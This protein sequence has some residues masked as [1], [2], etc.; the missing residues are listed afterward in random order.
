MNIMKNNKIKLTTTAVCFQALAAALNLVGGFIALSLRL[1]IYLDSIGTMLAAALLG[2]LCGMIPGLVSGLVSGFTSDIYALYYIPVQLITGILT[3]IV[4][5]KM[6][7][8]KWRLIP[9]AA[10]ISLPGTV[11]SSSI[12]AIVFGGITSSGS[13]ILVQL[14]SHTG[15]GLTASV[16]VVQ[17]LTDYADRVLSLMLTVAVLAA[18]PSSVKNS[19]WKGQTTN[20][21]V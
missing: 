14:L 17:A 8:R 3:G 15:L 2:P 20:G 16:C 1:P 7:P 12:T 11:V 4:F 10:L 21:T 18:I 13:T 5:R 6:Q 19:I 9:A